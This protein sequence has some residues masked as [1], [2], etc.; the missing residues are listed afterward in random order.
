MKKNNILI[1]TFAAACIIL[2]APINAFSVKESFQKAKNAFYNKYIYSERYFIKK[3]ENKLDKN[4]KTFILDKNAPTMMRPERNKYEVGDYEYLT[5]TWYNRGTWKAI[6]EV[7]FT[8]GPCVKIVK[9]VRFLSYTLLSKHIIHTLKDALKTSVKDAQLENNS[10]H[11]LVKHENKEFE[12]IV[13]YPSNGQKLNNAAKRAV[14]DN[15]WQGLE[16][17]L[18][19]Y[20]PDVYLTSTQT[21]LAEVYKIKNF[22]RLICH[23]VAGLKKEK[24]SYN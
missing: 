4:L 18:I 17:I 14:A 8:D 12:L 6:V 5:T 19:M 13:F 23:I 11:T 16:D 9:P 22:D 2:S 1:T 21:K 10:I 20:K 15:D 7:K 3:E 24:F